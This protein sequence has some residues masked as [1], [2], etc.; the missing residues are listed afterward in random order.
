MDNLLISGERRMTTSRLAE[1]AARAAAALS[2]LGIG[3][4]DGFA[5]FMRNDFAFFEAQNAAGLLG[6]YVAPINW[7]FKPDEAGYILTDSQARA[8]IVH[9]DLLPLI[10]P[11][12]P[13]GL[14][15]FQV[16]T[17]PEILQ[18]YG[19]AEEAGRL[20]GGAPSWDE[21]IAGFDPWD[22]PKMPERG[23]MI[24]TSG[25]TGQPKGV[26]RRPL[27]PELQKAMAS[28]AGG[29]FGPRPG[30]RS[31]LNGP[32]Y[33]ASPNAQAR[34]ALN[35]GGDLI[36]QPRFEAEEF[37]D[38]VERHRI[39]HTHLVPTMFH[40]LLRLPEEVKRR[41]DASSLERVV[42]GAAPCPVE[43]KRA[44]IEWWGPV[45]YEYYGGSE[46]G[47]PIASNSEQWL[48]KPGTV[49]CVS[50]GCRV[51]ILDDDG[52]ALG[53]GEVGEIFA[54]TP[55][56]P[57]FAYQGMAE[58]RRE[59]EKDGMISLGDV[60]YLDEDGFLFLCDRKKDMV[61]SGGVNIYP[62][63]IEAALIILDGVK[64]C[65]VFGIPDE[66]FGESLAAMI[67]FEDGVRLSEAAVRSHLEAR[68]ARY[69][70]P[71]LIEFRSGLPREENGKIYKRKLRAPFWEDSGRAI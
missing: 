11:A 25:T 51:A 71:K 50:P 70:L 57:Q 45:F 42:H 8:L 58:A 32:C 21:W 44:M 43:T 47:T 39:T 37:L 59:M 26:R 15:V 40:R 35:G 54:Y 69:K 9:A 56:V 46:L 55:T 41:F 52:R 19:L 66:E 49:G 12:I 1:R 34:I 16:E 67:E 33:H 68:L 2:S 63:E 36:L 14:P 27:T 31:L 3:E 65:A 5:L 13:P 24:Y 18:A 64:D 29:S 17:P 28:Q 53:P 48:A 6:A 4:D 38:L 23:V 62:A 30:M 10:A 61:I 20:P 7:H 22:G 60:G